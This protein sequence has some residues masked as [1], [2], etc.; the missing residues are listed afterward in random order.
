[1]KLRILIE[2][3]Q[4]QTYPPR[5]PSRKGIVRQHTMATL[6]GGAPCMTAGGD[7]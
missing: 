5:C 4:S 3:V 2:Y 6:G 1:M 7:R